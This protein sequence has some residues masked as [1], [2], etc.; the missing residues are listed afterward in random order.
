MNVLGM[1]FH[2]E[3]YYLVE[4]DV[5]ARIQGDGTAFV[6]IAALGIKLSGELYMCR[7]K[8]VGSEIEQGH[9][10]A[11]V[12]L[13]KAIVSVKCAVSGTVLA[14]NPRL[15]SAP[16]LVH[17]DPYG[18]G[19]IAQLAPREWSA[20]RQR[21]VQGEAVLVAMAQHVQTWREQGE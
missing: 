12:E 13:T 10:I 6:G 9:A 11:L 20:D 18:D 15:E 5:W 4:H 7:A 8:P 1:V 17:R 2:N 16:E 19:R 3:L 21:L 14:V